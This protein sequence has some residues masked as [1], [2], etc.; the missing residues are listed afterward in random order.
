MVDRKDPTVGGYA[1]VS[2]SHKVKN[3]IN[4]LPFMVDAITHFNRHLDHQN[5]NSSLQMEVLL[6]LHSLKNGTK[7]PWAKVP[8]EG[9]GNLLAG[10]HARLV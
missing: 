7:Q 2:I 1:E 9:I 3:T 4:H 6:E 8:D 10:N 5:K